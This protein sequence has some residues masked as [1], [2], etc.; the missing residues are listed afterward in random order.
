MEEEEKGDGQRLKKKDGHNIAVLSEGTLKRSRAQ[1][2]LPNSKN[3][4]LIIKS[5]AISGVT[6]IN[7]LKIT[8]II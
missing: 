4:A 3:H 7:A 1:G 2:K 8:Q 6:V 5:L